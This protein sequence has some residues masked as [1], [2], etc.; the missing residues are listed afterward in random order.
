VHVNK[1]AWFIFYHDPFV[2][3]CKFDVQGTIVKKWTGE[4]A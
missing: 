2:P 4:N 1:D 3:A